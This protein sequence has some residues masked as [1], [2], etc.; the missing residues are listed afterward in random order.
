MVVGTNDASKYNGN[1]AQI[2]EIED[3]FIHD[4]YN[5]LAYYDLALLKVSSSIVFGIAVHPIC[6]SLIPNF[7]PDEWERSFVQL[8]GFGPSQLDKNV[9]L[10]A[11]SIQIFSSQRCSEAYSPVTLR[12][13][14]QR[15]RNS[16]LPDGFK[17]FLICGRNPFK[18]TAVCGG[19]SGANAIGYD[20]RKKRYVARALV[21][22]NIVE[23]SDY[24]YPSILVRL[25]SPRAIN[26][27]KKNVLVKD[28]GEH[29][30]IG[31]KCQIDEN[32][33]NSGKNPGR[34]RDFS[35]N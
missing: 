10:K 14:D 7:S 27:F 16:S 28:A 19:D 18:T 15:I 25:D 17:D 20:D 32:S 29:D 9:T 21:H 5:H 23:C 34:T 24:G 30:G 2:K 3:F 13:D 35:M 22:G 31:K 6:I 26:F 1:D 11:D 8:V 33:K 4:D 12:L